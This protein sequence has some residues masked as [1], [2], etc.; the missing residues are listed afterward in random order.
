MRTS[1]H[2]LVSLLTLS[3]PSL[4]DGTVAWQQI[5][6]TLSSTAI[7]KGILAQGYETPTITN[8]S[9]QIQSGFLAHPLLVNNSPFVVSGLPDLKRPEG[10]G[11]FS[12]L[13]DTVFSDIDGDSLS[14][15]TIDSGAGSVTFVHG[16]TLLL[17]SAANISGTSRIIIVATDGSDT[18]KDTFRLTTSHPDALVLHPTPTRKSTELAV[19]I[20]KAMAASVQGAGAGRLGIGSVSDGTEGLS[21]DV[22]FPGAA[23]VSVSIFDNL[24]NP[25]ISFAQ[26]LG[27][28]RLRALARTTD[29]RWILPVSWN[30]R[31]S[32][33][34]AVPTGVY[35][36]KLELITVDG[37]KLETVKHLGVKG[38]N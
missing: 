19:S 26:D 12:I 35:L 32:D 13:L 30:L 9:S 28:S 15:S 3:A 22:L 18:A 23:S 20:H 29:G 11:E 24:G 14:Y 16:D 8:T 1:I 21:V 2:L 6:G 5:G 27:T 7:L 4:A 38:R 10:F 17:S 37:Q 33:G 25:V 31:S 34:T 36:W